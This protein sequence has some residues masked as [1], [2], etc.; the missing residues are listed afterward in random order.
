MQVQAEER[1]RLINSGDQEDEVLVEERITYWNTYCC[2]CLG[3]KYDRKTALKYLIPL[4][5]LLILGCAYLLVYILILPP[6]INEA[7]N[8]PDSTQIQSIFVKN[9]N[10]IEVDLSLLIN[11]DE[12]ISVK[13]DVN[14][15]DISIFTKEQN[16]KQRIARFTMP[17]FQV[18]P[19][20]KSIS[21]YASIEIRD[22]NYQWIHWF[23]KQSAKYGFDNQTFVLSSTPKVHIPILLATFATK[24]KKIY[25][26]EPGI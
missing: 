21:Q 18:F 8:G 3:T 19:K 11:I 5:V 26:F 15:G 16:S 22:I 12:P 10:P 17:E 9:I 25:Y 23:I 7:L 6:V 4:T 20:V 1:E 13:A 24:M 14:L 2:N